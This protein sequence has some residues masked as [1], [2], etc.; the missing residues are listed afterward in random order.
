MFNGR[1]SFYVSE[2]DIHDT[3][4]S[5]TGSQIQSTVLLTL[6]SYDE[7]DSYESNGLKDL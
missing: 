4:T 2:S 6:N 3:M 1:D 5:K 7:I